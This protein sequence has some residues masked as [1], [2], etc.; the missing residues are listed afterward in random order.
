MD[1]SWSSGSVSAAKM[2][3]AWR[4]DDG[5]YWTG[6]QFDLDIMWPDEKPTWTAG[7]IMLA[8]DALTEHTAASHLFQEVNLLESP[9]KSQEAASK[10]LW[11]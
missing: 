7:A 4:L 6:Y 10:R 1:M 5:S 3:S 11:Q 9:E 8:A 2:A